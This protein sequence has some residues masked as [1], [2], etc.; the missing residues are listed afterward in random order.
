MLAVLIIFPLLLHR[1]VAFELY[2][3]FGKFVAVGV[4]ARYEV[5]EDNSVYTLALVFGF[6]GYKEQVYHVGVTLD[7][8]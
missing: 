5:V 7:C 1:F 6:Y 2:V 3:A 8:A 4:E